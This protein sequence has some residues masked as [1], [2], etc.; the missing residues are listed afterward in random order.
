MSDPEYRKSLL[1]EK[2]NIATKLQSVV[3]EINFYEF[4]KPT[5]DAANISVAKISNLISQSFI[6]LEGIHSALT[7]IIQVSNLSSLDDRGELFD[8]IGSVREYRVSSNFPQKLKLKAALAFI[9]GCILGMVVVFGRRVL[10]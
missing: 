6:E 7:G 9:L 8:L 3:T 1:Q 4:N 10:R 5:G 2:I